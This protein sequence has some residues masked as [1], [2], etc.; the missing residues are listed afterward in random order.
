[1]TTKYI[2]ELCDTSGE[3]KPI[4]RL[5]SQTPFMAVN[6]GDRFDDVGW[7]R[8]DDVGILYSIEKPKRYTVHSI[9]HLVFPNSGGLAV[10]Y[11]LNL[12]P[13]SGPSSPV[14]GND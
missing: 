13:Y 7:E 2:L 14:W 11:C 1:M 8:L 12:E 6:I 4:V 5:E 3:H 9:K 10:K